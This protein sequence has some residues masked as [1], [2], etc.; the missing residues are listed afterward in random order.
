MH[1]DRAFSFKVLYYTGMNE[2]RFLQE[3]S[4]KNPPDMTAVYPCGTG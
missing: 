2:K 1:N 3:I 4:Q